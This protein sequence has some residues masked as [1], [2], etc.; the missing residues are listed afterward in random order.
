MN[1]R[2]WISERLVGR[3]V[4]CLALLLLGGLLP[5]PVQAQGIL[6][7]F[8]KAGLAGPLDPA[9]YAGECNFSNLPGIVWWGTESQMTLERLASLAG[10]IYWFSPDEPLLRGTEGR[11]IRMPAHLPFE[12]SASAPVVYYQ[13][14]EMVSLKDNAVQEWT[15]DPDDKGQSILDLSGIGLFRLGYF[16]YYP[17]EAGL[18]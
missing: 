11:D 2:A 16:A 6:Q 9:L 12:D 7:S 17:S 18:G 14:D 4:S 3:F 10:P 8:Q 15:L 5:G 1:G 13:L